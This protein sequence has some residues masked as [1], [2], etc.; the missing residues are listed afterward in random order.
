VL[1]V[2]FLDRK[3]GI[4]YRH[5]RCVW[6]PGRSPCAEVCR[7]KHCSDSEFPY[8]FECLQHHIKT[9]HPE[10]FN[11][12][13]NGWRKLGPGFQE[14]WQR[15]GKSRPTNYSIQKKAKVAQDVKWASWAVCLQSKIPRV[16]T[17]KDIAAKRESA[18]TQKIETI[19]KQGAIFGI[20]SFDSK[21]DKRTGSVT[22]IAERFARKI[23]GNA[24]DE[25]TKRLE[26]ELDRKGIGFLLN[27]YKGAKV[28][29]FFNDGDIS[30]IS[31]AS[32]EPETDA[33]VSV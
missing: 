19:L 17:T 30:P 23:L 8:I 32:S 2:R 4:G 3:L 11:D 21:G 29:G 16:S 9:F 10:Q 28:Y 13:M 27:Y 31:D 33:S 25:A 6:C 24:L 7:L 14:D 20:P 15:L 26:G 5:I 22:T 1:T 12:F 18:L